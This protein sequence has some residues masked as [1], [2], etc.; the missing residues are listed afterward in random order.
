MLVL[1]AE[2]IVFFSLLTYKNKIDGTYSM[3]EG[4]KHIQNFGHK[5]SKNR[6]LG[7]IILKW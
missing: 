5:L 4:S 6:M 1:I 7:R 2:K 3:H